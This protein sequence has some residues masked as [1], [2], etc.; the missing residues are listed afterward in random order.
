MYMPGGN[1]LEKQVMNRSS[2]TLLLSSSGVSGFV[3]FCRVR[4]EKVSGFVGFCRVG[5]QIVSRI[6]FLAVEFLRSRK[7]L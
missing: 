3:G 2:W 1:L 6:G 7:L 4:V 5:N